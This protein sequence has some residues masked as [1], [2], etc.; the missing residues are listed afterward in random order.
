MKKNF[1]PED[2]HQYLQN[3]TAK[4]FFVAFSGGVDSLVLLHSLYTLR[5]KNSKLKITAI[6]IDH[7]LSENSQNW[8]KHCIS[9]CEKLEIPCIV[10]QIAVKVKLTNKH[11]KE[12]LARELRYEALVEV[13]VASEAKDPLLLTA[14]HADDQAETLFLQ[15]FRGAG[16]KGLSAISE[17]KTLTDKKTGNTILLLRPLLFFSRAELLDYAKSENLHWVEDESNLDLKIARNFVRHKILPEI[18][19]NWPEVLVTLRRSAENCQEASYLID[20]L[21]KEDLQ[22]VFGSVENTLSI[23]KLLALE[24][25][26]QKNVIRYWIHNFNLPLP[27]SAKLT[28]IQKTVLLAASDRNPLVNW[29]GVEIRRFRDN[30][31]AMSPLK[32]HDAN[33]ILSWDLKTPLKLPGDLGTLKVKWNEEN[34]TIDT[35]KITVQFRHGGE[36]LKKI[37]QEKSIPPWLRDRIPLIYYGEKLMIIVGVK[38]CKKCNFSVVFDVVK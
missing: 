1:N 16:V 37:F 3:F 6:H 23:S 5:Q 17:R 11:S 32:P 7:G 27:S 34:F 36:K 26:R 4:H 2:L 12:A 19:N 25:A 8:A 31:Y 14:H 10:K 29:R 9:F 30:L 33:L 38:I 22:K 35:T 20:Y 13:A 24:N 15:L 28:E 18:K 21:A